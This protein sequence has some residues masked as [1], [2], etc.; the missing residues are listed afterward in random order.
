M[1]RTEMF[2][3]MPE[4]LLLC[5]LICGA[6]IKAP[7]EMMRPGSDMRMDMLSQVP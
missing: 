4:M 2:G 1:Q 6:T 5:T 7:R 3:R